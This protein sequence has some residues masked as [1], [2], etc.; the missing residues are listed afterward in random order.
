MRALSLVG[1]SADLPGCV[2]KGTE[3]LWIEDS[4]LLLELNCLH[5]IDMTKLSPTVFSV[6]VVAIGTLLVSAASSRAE[7]T[8]KFVA[9]N[10]NKRGRGTDERRDLAS[11]PHA[12]PK[13]SIEC[14]HHSAASGP[15]GAGS[16]S[17][18]CRS[19]KEDRKRV[20]SRV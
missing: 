3:I 11:V 4:A 18:S 14:P 20:R 7:R 13:R 15:T 9:T 1:A 16:R 6:L 17:G 10:G 5:G 19:R 2:A 12:M 8:M